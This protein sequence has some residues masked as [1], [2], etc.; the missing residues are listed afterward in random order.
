[1]SPSFQSLP[2][3]S[4]LWSVRGGGNSCLLQIQGKEVMS[5]SASCLWFQVNGLSRLLCWFSGWQVRVCDHVCGLWGCRWIMSAANSRGLEVCVQCRA[6]LWLRVWYSRS[7]PV[8]S[9]IND[10]SCWSGRRS[11]GGVRWSEARGWLTG[12]NK[13]ARRMRPVKSVKGEDKFESYSD[14]CSKTAAATLSKD[15]SICTIN[16]AL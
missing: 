13:Q 8:A 7:P 5:V 4:C 15:L 16:L 2:S 12:Q 1:M 11:R 9:E 3:V 14:T 10:V 6:C